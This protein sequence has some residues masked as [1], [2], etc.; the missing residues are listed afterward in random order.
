MRKDILTFEVLFDWLAQWPRLVVL[1]FAL[2]IALPGTSALPPLDRDESR[3][4]QATVQ[5]LET[6][7]FIAIRYQDTERNKKPVGVY[8]LQALSVS[9]LSDVADREIWAHRI[10]SILAALLAALFAFEIGRTLFDVR[11]GLLGALLLSASPLFVG[12]ATIA[13]TD[14]PLLATILAAQWALARIYLRATN[15]EGGAV[16]ITHVLPFWIAIGLGALLKGPVA[17]MVCGLT[18]LALCLRKP[19]LAWLTSLRPVLG[20]G[21]VALIVAPWAVAIGIETEG[22]FFLE[23]IGV[24]MLGKVAAVQESH[25]APP[26]AYAALVW[27]TFWPGA[28][29]LLPG[30][31]FLWTERRTAAVAFC[32]AWAFPTWLVFE[33][34]S[35]KLPHYVLPAYPALA[36]LAAA[37]IING[38]GRGL[39]QKFSTGLWVLG[40][41]AILALLLA[42]PARLS[43]GGVQAIDLVAAA[44]FATA[45]IAV[46]AAAWRGRRIAAALTAC[47]AGAALAAHLLESALPRFDALQLTPRLEAVLEREGVHPLMS[48]DAKPVILIGYHEPSAVFLLGTPT[49]LTNPHNAAVAL[50]DGRSNIAVAEER[51]RV[52]FE[53]EAAALGVKLTALA[54]LDGLNYSRSETA[55]LT[56]YRA[57]P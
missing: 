46:G 50:A 28:L 8:W 3:F 55:R 32:A 49:L 51:T 10:P 17:P 1:A 23:A 13:K 47:L 35:T 41:L 44:G 43:S 20:A 9:T 56:I 31:I 12:E 6:G 37:A 2:A 22:R 39:T 14:M 40:G 48:Q 7:D 24:D 26:G 36:L 30:L 19:Y 27:I 16:P 52:L 11:T 29:F 18:V 25:G 34:A 5:M 4:A 45:A 57:A 54:S 15:D 21:I 33:A 38:A 42:A 53:T